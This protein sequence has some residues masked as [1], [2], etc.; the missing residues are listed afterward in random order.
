MIENSR[1]SLGYNLKYL[2]I[3]IRDDWSIRDHLEKT[4]NKAGIMANILSRLMVNKK[5]TTE[6]KRRLSKR[7]KFGTIVWCAT[8]GGRSKFIPEGG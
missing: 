8:M 7:F 1:I 6:K 4:A 3:T 5:G 2:A